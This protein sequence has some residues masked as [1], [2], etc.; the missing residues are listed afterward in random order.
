PAQMGPSLRFILERILPEKI[1]PKISLLIDALREHVRLPGAPE[2]K[3]FTYLV[4]RG[5]GKKDPKA[6]DYLRYASE[7]AAC[8]GEPDLQAILLVLRELGFADMPARCKELSAERFN[9]APAILNQFQVYAQAYRPNKLGTL[10]AVFKDIATLN[11]Y[12]TLHLD[13]FGMAAE[14]VALERHL[15]DRGIACIVD[16]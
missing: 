3:H 12:R 11:D 16:T 7:H 9:H 5:S 2:R 13:A 10:P 15:L 1:D 8:P 4:R 6:D 14:V